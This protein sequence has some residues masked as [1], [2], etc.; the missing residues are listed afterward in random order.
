MYVGQLRE[1]LSEASRVMGYDASEC[2]MGVRVLWGNLRALG[3][4]LTPLYVPC[5]DEIEL[6]YSDESSLIIKRSDGICSHMTVQ[7]M[8]DEVAKLDD[9]RSV[10]LE[11][12]SSADLIHYADIDGL[13][14][15]D[16]AGEVYLHPWDLNQNGNTRDQDVSA[17][18]FG[19]IRIVG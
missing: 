17:W 16:K 13:L 12:I 11:Y 1:R 9:N 3:K 6:I 4:G 14:L 2:P 5:I 18:R 19:S 8:L 15:D 10:F 7:M